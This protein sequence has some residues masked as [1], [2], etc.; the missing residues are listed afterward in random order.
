MGKKELQHDLFHVNLDSSLDVALYRQLMNSIREWM[1]KQELGAS[2]PPE[3]EWAKRLGVTRN[4]V[5]RAVKPFIDDG[6]FER[7]TKAGTILVSKEIVQK[8]NLQLHPLLGMS[9]IFESKPKIKVVLYV[10]NEASKQK[11]VNVLQHWQMLSQE[12]SFEWVWTPESVKDIQAY[13]QFARSQKADLLLVDHAQSKALGDALLDVPCPPSLKDEGMERWWHF[14]D[15]APSERLRFLPLCHAVFGVIAHRGMLNQ[16]NCPMPKAMGYQ[17][18]LNYV[19]RLCQGWLASPLPHKVFYGSSQLLT[20]LSH[21]KDYEEH[22]IDSWAGKCR[23]ALE[24]LK[25]AQEAV[26]PLDQ[27]AYQQIESMV[28]ERSAL[29]VGNL[30]AFHEVLERDQNTFAFAPLL[31]SEEQRYPTGV[32]GFG[33]SAASANFE[34]LDVL[35]DLFY[36]ENMQAYFTEQF[37]MAN[38]HRSTPAVLA[39]TFFEDESMDLAPYLQ[40]FR[41]NDKAQTHRW[42]SFMMGA[43]SRRFEDGFR[44]RDFERTE[45]SLREMASRTMKAS[46]LS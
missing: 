3:V 32:Y 26:G 24:M 18:M 37:G 10:S 19:Q 38:F 35:L 45:L 16:L 13:G 2:L 20:C 41:N 28:S 17:C 31:P 15:E 8:S 33:V 29:F 7:R 14:S 34:R 12:V 4:T 30:Y 27:G 43:A 22:R 23:Q 6:H 25:G 39:E 5:R 36:G 11:W 9:G 42:L 21:M 46:M 44:D 1:L 40:A